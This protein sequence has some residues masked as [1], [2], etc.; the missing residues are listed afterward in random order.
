MNDEYEGTAASSFIPNPSSFRARDF[1][2]PRRLLERWIALL[3]FLVYD[4]FAEIIVKSLHGG[5]NVSRLR[6]RADKAGSVNNRALGAGLCRLVGVW[7]N[8]TEG[9]GY[10]NRDDSRQQCAGDLEFG[11]KHGFKAPVDERR[12]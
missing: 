5:G 7:R 8:W 4:P 10:A 11:Q 6:V 12:F 3:V 1:P 2:M 9:N